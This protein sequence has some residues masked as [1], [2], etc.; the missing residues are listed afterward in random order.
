MHLNLYFSTLTLKLFNSGT[1]LLL[2]ITITAALKASL[3]LN[4]LPVQH[5]YM[6]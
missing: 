4:T 3:F 2:T 6:L 5:I 1:K